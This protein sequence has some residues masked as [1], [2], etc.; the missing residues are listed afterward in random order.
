MWPWRRQGF[1][2]YVCDRPRLDV[3]ALVHV[4]GRVCLCD[5]CL[6]KCVASIER[7]MNGPY[8]EQ[9]RRFAP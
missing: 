8:W 3:Y 9:L 1:R 6:R 7:H 4:K 5:E 2:C